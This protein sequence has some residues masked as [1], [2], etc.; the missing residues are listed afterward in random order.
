MRIRFRYPPRHPDAKL[1]DAIGT[2]TKVNRTRA[3]V[4]F[5]EH[6]VWL[7]PIDELQLAGDPLGQGEHIA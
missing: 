6:G 3:S 2:L 4:D 7:W 1:N 5:G